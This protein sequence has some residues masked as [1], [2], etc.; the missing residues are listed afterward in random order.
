[1]SYGQTYSVGR[2]NTQ[3]A[4][5]PVG[6]A[7]GLSRSLSDKMDV[8]VHGTRCKQVGHICMDQCMFAVSVDP[9]RAVRPMDEVSYGDLV[10][11]MGADGEERITAEELADIRETINYEVTCNFGARLEKVYV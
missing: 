8:L 1:M 9:R 3:I 4:T 10:T 2:Q 11:V 7:D 5:I 6:Y